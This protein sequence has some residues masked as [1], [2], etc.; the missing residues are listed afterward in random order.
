MS[1][2]TQI[3]TFTTKDGLSSGDPE[4]IIS[5][6]DVDAEFGA[7]STAIATKYDSADLASQAQAE[8]ESAS[9]VLMSPLRVANWADANAGIV[10]DLQALADPNANRMVY[11]DD[12]DGAMQFLT[13][14]T[15]LTLDQATDTLKLS[16]LGL[17]DL[18]DPNADRLIYWDDSDGALNWLTV[19]NG[20]SV[21]S[22]DTMGL[23]DVA[24][25][26]AQPVVITNGTFTFDLSSITEL[27]AEGVTQAQDKIVVSD[28]GTIKVMPW[29]QMGIPVVSSAAN[30]NFALTDVNTI[31]RNT[32]TGIVWT[33]D[34]DAT[35]DLEIGSFIIC[36]N[37]HASAS[38]T[39]TAGAGVALYSTFNAG[40]TAAQSDTVDA[41]GSAI[42]FKVGA[43]AW[44]ITGDISDT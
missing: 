16:F 38:L 15:G 32:G 44:Q 37:H 1:D 4:K 12:T 23:T 2:Y 10:G 26:A 9:G 22:D 17:Q 11:W 41:G 13:A 35:T 8:A 30:Q 18:A 29:D 31:Q 14:G 28:N 42:L 19:D 6:A 20:I 40:G 25:G 39:I 24:A 33:I 21:D 3:T 34:P 5:G 7:I 36:V 27:A 43:D